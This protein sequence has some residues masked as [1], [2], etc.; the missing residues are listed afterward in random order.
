MIYN[1]KNIRSIVEIMGIIDLQFSG[2]LL[3][4]L[5]W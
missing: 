3:A 2:C 4:S 1:A 5:P